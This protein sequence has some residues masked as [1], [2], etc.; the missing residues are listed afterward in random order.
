ML[1]LGHRIVILLFVD[2]KLGLDSGFFVKH[3]PNRG[4]LIPT[5]FSIGE[6]LEGLVEGKRK[7]DRNGRGFLVSHAADRV[8]ANMSG[9]R[10]FNV[11][12][13][14][15]T[16]IHIVSYPERNCQKAVCRSRSGCR[17]KSNNS[18]SIKRDA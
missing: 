16:I 1:G 3:L 14:Y 8:T 2:P 10:K 17:E 11:D 9:P 6:R 15:D 4:R 13:V 7:G 12:K 5:M 18:C